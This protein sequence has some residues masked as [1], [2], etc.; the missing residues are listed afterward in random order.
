MR[1]FAARFIN[2]FVDRKPILITI[3]VI[4]II[5]LLIILFC[6]LF[7]WPVRITISI[8]DEG[9]ENIVGTR[10]DV[11]RFTA[12]AVK[13]G[14]PLA[15]N[16]EWT[17]D[18]GRVIMETLKTDDGYENTVAKWE[19]PTEE[20][21]YGITA[22]FDGYSKTKYI[23]IIGNDLSESFKN[24]A[25]I[26]VQDTDSDGL[27]DIYESSTSKT[28]EKKMDTDED[29]LND[30]DE[31][32]MGLDP[33][34]QDS[35]GDGVLD[36]ERRLEYTFK[37]DNVTMKMAGK[38]NFTQTSV[39]KYDTETLNNVPYVIDGLYSIYTAA[40]PESA[41][42]TIKYDKSKLEGSNIK[43]SNLSVYS[44]DEDT[45]NF[46]ALQTTVTESEVIFNVN[47]FGEDGSEFGKY[48]IAD[49]SKLTS[50]LKTD[51]VFLIDNSG[52][53]F[54]QN[55]SGEPEENDIEFKRIDVVN[56]LIDKLQGVSEDG[57]RN[58]DNYRFGAGELKFEY[59]ELSPLTSDGI[60]VKNAV[61]KLKE[62][63]NFTGTYIGA[64]FE[65]ALKQFKDEQSKNRKY[66]ILIS[67]GKDTEDREGYDEKLLESQITIAKEKG[68]KVYAV[69]LGNS[70]DEK[71]LTKISSETDGKYY[72]ASTADDLK[73]IFQKIAAELNY[74]L[75]DT[76]NDGKDD[77]VL[78]AD[79]DFLVGRDGFSFA[80]FKNT[81]T[82]TG[83][84]YGMAL[85]AK[86]LYED[87]LPDS[88]PYMKINVNNV[89]T[90]EAPPANP[91]DISR[92]DF[93]S[94]RTYAPEG[95]SVLTNI[96]ANFWSGVT[97]G[98]LTINATD[99]ASLTGLGFTTYTVPYKDKNAGFSGYENISFDMKNYL[100]AEEPEENPLEDSDVELLRTLARLDILKYRDEKTNFYDNNDK[101]FEELKTRLSSGSPVLIMINEQY[102]VLGVKLLANA[103]N[104]N[105]YKI[106]VY[107][108]NYAGVPK[109]IE[110]ERSKFSD[111][112]EISNIIT[113]KYEYKFK[114][115]GVDVAIYLS[116]PFVVSR[117]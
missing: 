13:D 95:L 94:L 116:T 53:M 3:S 102:A 113:D 69:G 64:G 45:G 74:N 106:E 83:Y 101:A 6:V 96:P 59:T 31:I 18:G 1:N 77:S 38:G 87:D 76:D 110:I 107:D 91:K 97:S 47:D 12:S 26:Y 49:T 8:V 56:D 43:I 22:G 86:L 37:M 112:E 75:Y 104:M 92:E 89:G 14:K 63:Y 68:V 108:P 117:G 41:Q 48:F 33:K 51:V 79:S 88:L 72:F 98:I 17:V 90:V 115:Q 99:K 65:G 61:E 103:K 85:Y 32:M 29:G 66:I 2:W 55:E 25:T 57:S 46:T 4:L 10:T 105:K 62:D 27:T 67:D 23:T 16:Y 80:N 5:I 81:Q 93:T 30:G 24:D 20:G 44:L 40:K 11:L 60:A 7:L 114:Y 82:T 100:A 109:Y 111:V 58:K 70:I 28:D 21:T 71:S 73:N 19:L 42:I 50:Y 84:S 9:M 36:G 35:K 34:N 15:A 54:P 78:L 52:S 39:D